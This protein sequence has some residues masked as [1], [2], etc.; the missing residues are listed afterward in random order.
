MTSDTGYREAFVW[1]WL[2]GE[3]RPVVAG[4]L[5]LTG[6][7]QLVFNYGRS[8]LA[9]ENAIALY[10]PELPLRPGVLPLLSGLAMP[11]C[12]RDAAPDAWRRACG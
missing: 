3:T 4:R 7:R 10:E 2:P 11:N 1:V 6:D 12:I 9:R 8:Y 5:A